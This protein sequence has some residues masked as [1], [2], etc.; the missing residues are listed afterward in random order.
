MATMMRAAR[1]IFSLKRLSAAVH[2]SK[3]LSEGLRRD[4]IPAD[5]GVEARRLA[6]GTYQVLPM[7]RTLMPSARVFQRYGF[8]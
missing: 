1:T 6:K 3:R 5:C 4:G 7:L 8:M 2:G